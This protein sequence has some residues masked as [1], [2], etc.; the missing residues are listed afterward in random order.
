MLIAIDPGKT[1]GFAVYISGKLVEARA[2]KEKELLNQKPAGGGVLVCELPVVYASRNVPANDL[3]ALAVVV[4]DIAGNYRRHGFETVL[5]TPRTW[6]GTVPKEIHNRRVLRQ[7]T[8]QERSILPKRPRA[9]NYDH[10][11]IDAVGLGLWFLKSKGK[12]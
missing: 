12:R 2:I 8:E 7:L 1:S 3:I 4:G 9:K 5:V 11:M 10:N 6:K